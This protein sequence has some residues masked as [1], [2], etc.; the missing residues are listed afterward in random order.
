MLLGIKHEET[1]SHDFH[2]KM[3]SLFIISKPA[4]CSSL[5]ICPFFQLSML[6]YASFK[7]GSST[8]KG[9][10]LLTEAMC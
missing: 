8:V 2:K 6:G 1:G 9:H 3:V 5:E 7:Q 4:N 10:A